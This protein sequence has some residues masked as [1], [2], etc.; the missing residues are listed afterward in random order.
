M[1]KKSASSTALRP[2]F[3]A[4]HRD[5]PVWDK[6]DDDLKVRIGKL[7]ADKK[8][9]ERAVAIHDV[10]LEEFP[11]AHCEL[12]YTGPL[13]LLIA[14]IL[15][16]QCT[17]ARVNMVTPALFERFPTAVALAEADVEE[18]E[19][20]VKTTGFYRNKAKA[21]KSACADIVANFGGEVPEDIEKLLTLRG[22]ARKTANVVRTNCFGYPG[23]T[24]DTHFQRLTK[25]MGLTTN[26]DPQ[27]IEAD[28]ANLLPPERWCHFTHAIILHGR[29]TCKAR[30]PNC[31]EC[32]VAP[33]CPS[34]FQV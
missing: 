22:V 18:I 24:V 5:S 16:A 11:E 27:K 19:E 30:K 12:N 32:R 8:L 21:I 10:L 7:S 28:L 13:Q 1:A 33:L 4:Y 34:A 15:S 29:R 2:K 26:D 17:D 31:P 25:R 9:H 20:Y 3:A 6:V 14:T 23:L